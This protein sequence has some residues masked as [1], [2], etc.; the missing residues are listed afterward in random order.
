MTD[1]PKIDS[2]KSIKFRKI[3]LNN[4]ADSSPDTDLR[5]GSLGRA[6]MNFPRESSGSLAKV[7]T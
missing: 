1:L 5:H 3:T 7:K 2:N 6:S 4:R